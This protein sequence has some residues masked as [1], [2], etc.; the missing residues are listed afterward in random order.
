MGNVVPL[1]RAHRRWLLALGALLVLLGDYLD[2]VGSKEIRE[3]Y[4]K[5]FSAAFPNVAH[6]FVALI[7]AYVLL[8]ALFGRWSLIAR[9]R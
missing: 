8:V 2:F 6:V 7:A 9:S 3:Y 5:D 4:F 1:M